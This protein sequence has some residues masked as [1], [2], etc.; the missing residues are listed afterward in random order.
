MVG[1]DG[2]AAQSLTNKLFL[3]Y[4]CIIFHY[5]NR[6]KIVFVKILVLKYKTVNYF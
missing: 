4:S 6:G 5:F 1:T 3:L 2:S